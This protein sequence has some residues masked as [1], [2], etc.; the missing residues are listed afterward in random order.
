MT[1]ANLR[2]ACGAMFI[3]LALAFI[4]AVP[5]MA[6]TVVTVNGEPISDVQV[7]Q[8]LRLFRMEG[9][10]TGRNGALEQLI[11]EAIQIQEAKR[12]GINVSNAQVDDAF[13]QIARNLNVSRDRLQQMLQEG[14]VSSTTLQDRL[15]AA[16]AWNSLA[17]SAVAP[18][19][20]ISELELD[21]QA[22]QQLADFQNFDYI[23]KE[24]TFVG[25]SRSGQA[26]QYRSSFAGCGTA[27]ELSLAYTDVAVVDV[28]R[29]HATQMPDA[30]A[31]ELAGLNVGGITKPRA[32]A[33]GL[34]MLAICE[35]VQAQD[36]TF[37]K[38]GLRDDVGGDAMERETKAFL[39]RL[40]SQAKIIYQ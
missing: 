35:K 5:A 18:Q 27:V 22:A 12:I 7:D 10:N 20:Q 14:G 38:G 15:R 2:R 13:L 6:A 28:G 40:R 3:G 32:V 9:N 21:Q 36:L 4:P 29:R 37:V 39:E 11:T 17:E 24:V 26:N 31:K 23:L 33:S 19:V 34:S 1:L 8:R 30:I 16:I 25:G